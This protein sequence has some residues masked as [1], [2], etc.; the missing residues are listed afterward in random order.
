MSLEIEEEENWKSS[1]AVSTNAAIQHSDALR[2]Y[3]LAGPSLGASVS[4]PDPMGLVRQQLEANSAAATP[5]PA[6]AP[7]TPSL[8]GSRASGQL[9]VVHCFVWKKYCLDICCVQA[10]QR[11]R[12]RTRL[13]M[14][15][16]S[17][18]W[19]WLARLW[20]RRLQ[21]CVR[22]SFAKNISYSSTLYQPA[23]RP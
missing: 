8:A 13:L 12:P 23:A 10:K 9:S 18:K 6:A 16:H 22:P 15:R 4:S 7:A 2:V 3:G 1:T 11:Q 19:P 5:Q 14:S 17:Q 21:L 20:Q